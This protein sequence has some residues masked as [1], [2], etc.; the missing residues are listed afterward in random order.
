MRALLLRYGRLL[1]TVL[2]VLVPF[3]AG[4]K[5]LDLLA[6]LLIPKYIAQDFAAICG[7]YDSHFLPEMSGG[8]AAVAA[9]AR[10]LK[11]E[12]TSGLTQA[13]ALRTM[14]AAADTARA[15]ARERMHALS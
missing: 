13:D 1:T 7:K 12:V 11:I 6:R 8:S 3:S 15:V 4:A 10:H 5:D 2:L 14:V 9:Y